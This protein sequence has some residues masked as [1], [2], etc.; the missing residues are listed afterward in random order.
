VNLDLE[1]EFPSLK[2]IDGFWRSFACDTD[3]TKQSLMNLELRISKRKMNK[4]PRTS[5]VDQVDGRVGQPSRS[6]V[7]VRQGGGRYQCSVQNANTMVHF[8]FLPDTSQNADGLGDGRLVDNDLGES[9]FERSVSLDVLAILGQR[10]G[11]DA[12]QF[13][14]CQERLEQVASVHATTLG[15]AAGHDE[16]E[17]VDE[18]DDARPAFFGALFDFVEDGLDALFV[19]AFVFGTGHE[20]T[21]IEREEAGDKAGGD[22]TVDDALSK[23]FGD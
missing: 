4:L 2:L 19:L 3:T 6:Q 7:P 23:A 16:V 21:H 18:E 12:A 11:A 8:V 5:F 10:G 22:V 1:L 9:T 15:A 13:P 14:P 20:S 17:F